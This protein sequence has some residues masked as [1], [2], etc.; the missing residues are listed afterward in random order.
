MKETKIACFKKEKKGSLWQL[1]LSSRL[2]VL[3]KLDTVSLK[4]PSVYI[5]ASLWQD[6]FLE[7]AWSL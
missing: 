5:Q 1:S 4:A 6:C 2:I 7:R 3:A